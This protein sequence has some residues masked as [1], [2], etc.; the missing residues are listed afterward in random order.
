MPREAGLSLAELIIG[1]SLL[2]IVLA[3]AAKMISASQL[4]VRSVSISSDL[5]GLKLNISNDLDCE[6]TLGVPLPVTLACDPALFYTLR[7]KNGNALS[8][9]PTMG[10]D[11]RGRCLANSLVIET[12]RFKKD[13]VHQGFVDVGANQGWRDAFGGASGF[14][15]PYFNPANPTCPP[16][17]TVVGMAG[18]TPVCG[19]PLA[20]PPAPPP[21]PA[22]APAPP[23]SVGLPNSTVPPGDYGFET[24]L[25]THG[26]IV[27]VPA[28][29]NAS[30][31][32][33]SL[34]PNDTVY[35]D[36]PA[37]FGSTN[38]AS[39]GDRFG[40]GNNIYLG[41]ISFVEPG[42]RMA[43]CRI[44]INTNCNNKTQPGAGLIEDLA[45]CDY[46]D[47]AN[48][49]VGTLLPSWKNAS[50]TALVICKK[51]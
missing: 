1:V 11:V 5:A 26:N 18:S 41:F 37:D 22:G 13:L 48:G 32:D 14:C 10:F 39:I 15:K 25:V 30:E 46:V 50:C 35:R 24:R 23:T 17:D 45:K 42:T 28:G 9:S 16:G 44:A 6:K 43:V 12:R 2:T 29:F 21:P 33:F 4:S 34:F 38:D 47:P 40:W 19:I 8:L 31:C 49:S 51:P 20:P 7:K 36:S 3:A 27:P